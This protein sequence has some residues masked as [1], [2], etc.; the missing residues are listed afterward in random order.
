LT[1]AYK[2]TLLPYGHAWSVV[3][4]WHGCTSVE[5]KAERKATL[6]HRV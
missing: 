3:L 4:T 6:M 5:C 1:P 2:L